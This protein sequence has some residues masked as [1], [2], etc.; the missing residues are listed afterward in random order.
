MDI[1]VITMMMQL[2]RQVLI[3]EDELDL[4]E[5]LRSY[6]TDREHDVLTASTV[7]EALR[8]LA[9]ATPDMALI[10]LRLP[11]GHGRLIVQDIRKRQ[12]PTRIV[13]MTG[14]ADLEL[15]RELLASGVSDD[16]FKPIQL[17]ELNAL[18]TSTPPHS[19]AQPAHS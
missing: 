5:C 8:W 11:G 12:L 14:C 13:I 9:Q 7:D 17:R 19:S 4:L 10:D 3:V 1:T 2:P 6:L 15:R 16:L 18:L